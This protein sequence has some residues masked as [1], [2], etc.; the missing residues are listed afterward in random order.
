MI[1][2]I[3]TERGTFSYRS[4]GKPTAPPLVLVHGWPQSSY[5]WK[6]V[7]EALPDFYVITPDLRG[8]GDSERTLD[9]KAYKKDALG[10]DIF[11]LLEALGIDEFYLGG[12][13]WGFGCSARNG[14]TATRK[15]QEVDL[16][17]HGHYQQF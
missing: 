17:Q 9:V 14:N 6:E 1:Q 11:S 8:L 3:T 12:H 2:K 10:K 16:N 15:N 13:D 4:Y 5:C 7:A